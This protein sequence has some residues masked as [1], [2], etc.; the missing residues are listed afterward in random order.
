[1]S[2]GGVVGVAMLTDSATLSGGYNPTGSISFTLTAP[3]GTTTPEG[4]VT[5]TGDANYSSPSVLAT[6]VGVYTWHASYSGDTNNGPASDNG[7]NEGVTTVKASPSIATAASATACGVVGG[8]VISDS[9]VL[10]GGYDVMGG[11]IT[12]TLKAPDGTTA[13]SE[14]VNVHGDGTYSTPMGVTATEVGTYTWHASYTGDGLNNGAIDNGVNESVTTVKAGPVITTTPNQTTVPQGTATT[15]KDTAKLSGGYNE[16]GTITFT[17]VSPGGKTLDTE[18]VGVKGNGTYAT[19]AGYA[20]P[21]SAAA[22]VYQWNATYNSDGDNNA[23]V[24]LNDPAERVA[25]ITPCCNLQDISFNVYNSGARPGR[26]VQRPP[27]EY[28][29]G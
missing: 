12:F 5:V 1:M 27:R 17:L 4:S 14:T 18:T 21:K 15:L 2:N 11:Q 23:A 8:A 25:V 24:D 26:H 19:P 20:L 10:S 7:A 9:A 3:D 6:E 13:A 22:G 28:P 29:A 16:T